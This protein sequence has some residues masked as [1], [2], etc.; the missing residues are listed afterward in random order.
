MKNR[1]GLYLPFII[2]GIVAALWSGVWYYASS[3]TQTVISDTLI[4]EASQ[5]REWTC[6]NRRIS[7]F[8]FRIEVTCDAPTF[9]T[10]QDGKAGS[11]N[12][13]A[14]SVQARIADPTRAIATLTSPLKF[15]AQGGSI[16]LNWADAKTSLSGSTNS[17]GDFSLDMNQVTINIKTPNGETIIAGASR[18]NINLAQDAPDAPLSAPFKL[19][20]KLEGV[21]FAPL[22]AMAGNAQPLNLELHLRATHVPLKPNPD[23]KLALNAWREAGG[24]VSIA[25]L[26]LN[27][28]VIHIDTKGDLALDDANKITGK[29]SANFK[30]LNKLLENMNLNALSGFANNSVTLNFRNGKIML[31]PIPVGDLQAVY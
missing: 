27:K 12:L 24:G 28:G 5:G 21:T 14:L 22:D 16:N 19:L 10:K 1:L 2:L 7:G 3:R 6:P 30:G 17:F 26:D 25:L 23:W 18:I 8:P 9:V 11:G 15:E 13:G 20:A 31:G 29:L 4:K